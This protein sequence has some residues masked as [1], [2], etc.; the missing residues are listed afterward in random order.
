MVPSRSRVHGLTAFH[1]SN[2]GFSVQRHSGVKVWVVSIVYVAGCVCGCEHRPSTLEIEERLLGKNNTPIERLVIHGKYR[3]QPKSVYITNS[4]DVALLNE[5]LNE[6]ISGFRSGLACTG[7]LGFHNA[8]SVNMDILV[9]ESADSITLAQ[10]VPW[11]FSEPP[12]H[13]FLLTK[14]NFAPLRRI[15]FQLFN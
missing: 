4:V 10:S 8:G 15:L 2:I 11:S 6:P 3:G 14:T 9:P 5:A 7:N 12:F 13:T 1:Q